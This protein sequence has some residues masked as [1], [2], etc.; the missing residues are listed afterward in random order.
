VDRVRLLQIIKVAR[1]FRKQ[2]VQRRTSLDFESGTA[3]RVFLA[4]QDADW[5][6]AWRVTE[7]LLT[8]LRN[9]VRKD[10]A[11]F[12]LLTIPTPIQ[13]HP[14]TEFRNAFKDRLG[15]DTLSYPD[16][17]LQS[18]AEREA[19]PFVGLSS[20]FRNYAETESIFLHG[21]EGRIGVGH[22]NEDGHQLAGQIVAQSICDAYKEQKE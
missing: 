9:D 2:S 10:G 12:W 4:P 14:E 20:R 15:V 3:G 19:V 21:F 17:R 13:V 5:E 7:G 22:W 8:T 1:H 18:W 6:E 11:E 16:I